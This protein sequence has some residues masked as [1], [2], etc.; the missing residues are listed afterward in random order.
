MHI[1]VKKCFE[2]TKIK[3]VTDKLTGEVLSE[4]EEYCGEYSRRKKVEPFF[5]AFNSSNEPLALLSRGDRRLFD[6]FCVIMAYESNELVLN[7]PIKN[8]LCKELSMKSGSFSNSICRMVK[9][10]YLI[11]KSTGH[12]YVN[13]NLVYRGALNTLKEVRKEVLNSSAS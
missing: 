9:G 13:P 4:V 11:R 5:I 3:T 2:K 12:L 7:T 8:E 6:K 10:N 1:S